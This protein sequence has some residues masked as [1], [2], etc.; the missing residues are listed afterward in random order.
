MVDQQPESQ[1]LPPRPGS[2]VGVAVAYYG[3]LGLIGA[4]LAAWFLFSTVEAL[5]GGFCDPGAQVLCHYVQDFIAPTIALVVGVTLLP[6]A[7][8]L[9]RNP[10]QVGP[11]VGVAV[12]VGVVVALLPII[13]I[14]WAADPSGEFNIF[15]EKVPTVGLVV[16]FSGP[17]LW[18]LASAVIVWR[19]GGRQGERRALITGFGGGALVAIGTMIAVVAAQGIGSVGDMPLDGD[20]TMMESVGTGTLRLER[21]VQHV[22][23]GAAECFAGGG[24]Q[25]SVQFEPTQLPIEGRPLI[26]VAVTAARDEE[27]YVY[28]TVDEPETGRFHEMG[29]PPGSIAEARRDGTSG[30]FRFANLDGT[31]YRNGEAGPLDL[32]LEGTIEWTCPRQ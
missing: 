25:L 32:H 10:P 19:E 7:I 3:L 12:V 29:S 8:R 31:S 13:L 17:L 4:A 5:L 27:P 23:T 26:N 16:L 1:R 24:D 28:I 22:G 11:L 21:S 30:S 2:G 14:L 18:A 9:R 20:G 6:A 15:G